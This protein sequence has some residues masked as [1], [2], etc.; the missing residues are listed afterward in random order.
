MQFLGA[1]SD[2]LTGHVLTWD[3]LD[4]GGSVL[5]VVFPEDC[6]RR[7]DRSGAFWVVVF[8]HNPPCKAL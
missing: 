7:K 8:D 2:G 1:E 4:V 5:G 6:E 3:S